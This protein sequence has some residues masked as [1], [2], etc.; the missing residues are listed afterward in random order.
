M[1]FI[2]DILGDIAYL[3]FE[4][5]LGVFHW[6][7]LDKEAVKKDSKMALEKH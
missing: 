6:R 5:I 2:L 1:S 7:K 3:L 4:F